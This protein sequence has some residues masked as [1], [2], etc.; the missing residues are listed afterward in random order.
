MSK[1]INSFLSN[2]SGATAI[3][4]ALIA[5]LIALSAIAAMGSLSNKI[6]NEFNTIGNNFQALSSF[7][8]DHK[9]P[10]SRGSPH[11]ALGLFLPQYR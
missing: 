7:L 1:Q 6:S 11:W 3:E 2:D 9:S 10:A 5:A 4:Y 8:P